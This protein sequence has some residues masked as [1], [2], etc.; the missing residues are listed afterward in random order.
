MSHYEVA[1]IHLHTQEIVS[2]CGCDTFNCSECLNTSNLIN[3]TPQRS[4]S[5]TLFWCCKLVLKLGHYDVCVCVFR[6]T[7]H[8]ATFC[9]T[10][11]CKYWSWTTEA[12]T[13]FDLSRSSK[14]SLRPYYA[15]LPADVC[16]KSEVRFKP[17]KSFISTRKINWIRSLLSIEH[18]RLKLKK[19][20]ASLNDTQIINKLKRKKASRWWLPPLSRLCC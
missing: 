8:I 18:C 9:L 14:C 2:R 1:T 7:L 16:L 12:L 6:D 17:L 20:K 10:C 19:Y 3:I 11:S 13:V 4:N 5:I 15:V